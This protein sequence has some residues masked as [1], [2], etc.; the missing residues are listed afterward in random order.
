MLLLLLLLS[1]VKR[2]RIGKQAASIRVAS[3]TTSPLGNVDRRL[4]SPGTFINLFRVADGLVELG[5]VSSLHI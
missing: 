5:N 2:D 1:L 3:Y 4:E